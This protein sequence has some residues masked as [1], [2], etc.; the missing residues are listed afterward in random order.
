VSEE[1]AVAWLRQQIEGAKLAAGALAA[2]GTGQ[3]VVT[4]NGDCDYTVSDRAG[5]SEVMPLAD[6]WRE[7]V[8]ALIAAKDPRDIIADCEAKLALLDL[9]GRVIADGEGREYHDDGWSGLAVAR[10]SVRH[11]AFACRHR[12]GY[13]EHWSEAP[14]H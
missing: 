5:I 10:L 4:R 14:S 6:T 11:L 1:A 13:A 9:C 12:S 3:W 7:D 8:A 2:Y